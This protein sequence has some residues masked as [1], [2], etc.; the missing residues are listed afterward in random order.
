MQHCFKLHF[1]ASLW[2]FCP[3]DARLHSSQTTYKG[4]SMSACLTK[5]HCRAH[6]SVVSTLTSYYDP[7]IFM[8]PFKIKLS[9]SPPSDQEIIICLIPNKIAKLVEEKLLSGGHG[10]ELSS[11]VST[12]ILLH[13]AMLIKSKIDINGKWKFLT[14]NPDI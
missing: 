13:K 10:S 5:Q 8:Q 11:S 3:V 6:D 1:T 12:G 14:R 4:N 7:I 2:C 9:T